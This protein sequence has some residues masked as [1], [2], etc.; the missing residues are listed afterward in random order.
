M[1]KLVFFILTGFI[2]T[3]LQ[4]QEMLPDFSVYKVGGGRVVVAW[5]H[6]YQGIK[7]INIQ[8]STDSLN[9]FKTVG[10]MPDPTLQQNGFADVKP[11]SDNMFY[12]V[13]VMFEGGKYI[14]TKSKRPTLDSTGL[15]DAYNSGN[16][17]NTEVNLNPNFLPAGFQQSTYIFTSPDRYVRVELPY[18]KRKYD[19]KFFSE[20][21]Q[22]LFEM[23]NVK[24]KRFK[25]DRSYFATA[26]YINF[27]LYADGKL[28]ERHKVYLPKDF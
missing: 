28:M 16:R 7:Q 19:I 10:T 17:S 22:P 25:L 26:G 11:P 5:T 12:R 1:K 9:F 6:N 20:T 24:E 2:F 27:E 21:G 14:S 8:R 23:N 15:A 13:F 18:D 4:A 3:G